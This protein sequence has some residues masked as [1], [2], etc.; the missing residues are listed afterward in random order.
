MTT[1]PREERPAAVA[2][3]GRAK[4]KSDAKLRKENSPPAGN[5]QAPTDF[6]PQ[7]CPI[8]AEHFF[9]I[10]TVRGDDIG[11]PSHVRD[12]RFRR[13]VE[14]LHTLGPWVF[15]HLLDEIG[16]R[17]QGRTFIEDSARRYAELD[18][19]IVKQLGGDR[20][21]PSPIHRVAP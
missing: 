1:P 15:F 6:D 20:M 7:A 5:L 18:P 12:L 9:G 10:V 17:H 13:D 4:S 2:G 3:L 11:T 16:H 14:R 19:A 8:I 21:P